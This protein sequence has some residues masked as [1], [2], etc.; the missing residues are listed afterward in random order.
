MIRVH[1]LGVG[2]VL[3]G[4]SFTVPP[5][6]CLGVIGLNGAGKSTLLAT[7]AG[8]LHPDEG[9]V[10][11][12]PGCAYLPESCPLDPSIPVESWLKLAHRLPG[13]REDWAD[14]L[15]EVLPLPG[16]RAA[17]HLSQ[18]QRVRLGLRMTLCR[19]TPAWLLDDPFL[20]LDPIAQ[21]ATESAIAARCA[22]GPVIMASQNAEAMER[23][24]T[25]LLLLRDGKQVGFASLEQW[26]SR[27]RAVRIPLSRRDEIRSL[28]AS[29]LST[30]TRGA[31]VEVVLDD[32]SGEAVSTLQGTPIALS[33]LDLI[34]EV[35]A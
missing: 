29:V 25:H 21:R 32:P 14:E 19:H 5:D 35:T 1:N 27:Y 22:D 11:L 12:P 24:C 28:G 30:R 34:S 6:G 15:E 16:R 9:L 18:G 7:L 31:T 8:V 13:Y 23:L 20:G 17:A 3:T 4:I 2:D 10:E 33:L 26:R